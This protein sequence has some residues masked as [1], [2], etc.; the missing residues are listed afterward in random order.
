M[1]L[2]VNKTDFIGKHL[3]AVS[4]LNA[5]SIDTYITRYEE[6]YLI[7]LLGASLFDLF[8]ATPTATRFAALTAPFHKDKELCIVKSEGM[9]DMLKGFIY[10]EIVK[11]QAVKNTLSG[12]MVGQVENNVLASNDTLYNRYNEAIRT[13]WAIQWYI[14]ENLSTYPEYNGQPKGLAHWCL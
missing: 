9:I 2:L 6:N 10:W 5:T 8:K 1:G 4:A 12:N 3:I 14:R 13:Y 7:A 11:D